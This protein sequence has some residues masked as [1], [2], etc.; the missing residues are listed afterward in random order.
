MKKNTVIFVIIFAISLLFVACSSSAPEE[1]KGT[2]GKTTAASEE[3]TAAPGKNAASSEKIAVKMVTWG[4]GEA[5]RQ[6]A[7]EFSSR[8]DEV[9]F[10]IEVVTSYDEYISARVAANDLPE[11][12]DITPY[13]KVREFAAAGRL[14]D[15]TETKAA[16]FLLDSTKESCSY[17]GRLY[18]M[19]YQQQI[20]GCFYNPALFEKAGITTVPTTYSELVEVCKKLTAAGVKPFAA[21]YSDSWTISHLGS[22]ML[23]STLRGADDQWVADIASGKS[24]ANTPNVD[25]LFRFMDLLKTY[26]GDNYMDSTFDTGTNAFA[27]GEAAM[28]IQGDWSLETVNKVDPNMNP[29]L[30]AVPVSDDASYNK[31]AVDVSVAKTVNANLSEEKKEAVMKVLEYIYDPSDPSG[32][33]S[34]CFSFMGAGVPSVAY[35]SDVVNSFRYYTDYQN[36]VKKNMTCP[37]VYQMLPT[38]TDLGGVLQGYMAGLMTKEDTLKMLDTKNEELLP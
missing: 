16:S 38:G 25:E 23:S 17:N 1:T 22:C 20:I 21:T 10:T 8:Q 18:A 37:W 11:M 2:L 15:L 33:N 31:L 28:L 36:C 34:I 32:H 19:P 24:Y 3:T 6:S 12:Y 30:F 27:A 13:A 29:G 35:S 5:Y 4:G 26:S 9:E 14:L 7:E